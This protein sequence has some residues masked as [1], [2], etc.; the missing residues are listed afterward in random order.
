MK[1]LIHILHSEPP[2]PRIGQAVSPGRGRL[3]PSLRRAGSIDT[4]ALRCRRGGRLPGPSAKDSNPPRR[5]H[6]ITDVG[7]TSQPSSKLPRTG[8]PASSPGNTTSRLAGSVAG[9]LA[10][11]VALGVAQLVAG[12]TGP[13]AAPVVAVGSTAIDITPRPVTELAIS[14]FGPKDKTVLLTGIVVVLAVFAVAFG[15]LAVRRLAFGY[16]GLVVFTAIGLLAVTTRP[17]FRPVDVVPTIAGA[18][19]GVIALRLLVLEARSA[20]RVPPA[21]EETPGQAAAPARRA[22]DAP[23]RPAATG[24]LEAAEERREAPGSPRET[25][26]TEDAPSPPAP[27]PP[28]ATPPA[29]TPP[30]A[31]PPAATPPAAASTPETPPAGTPQPGTTPPRGAP[32]PV[33]VPN[34]GRRRFLVGSALAAGTAAATGLIGNSLSGRR[35][36]AGSRALLRIPAPSRPAP[37][38][39]AGTDLRIPGLSPFVT[40]GGSFYR[41]D[42]AIVLPQVSPQ[43]WQ[44]RVHGMV[45]REVTLTLDDLLH[46]PLTEAWVTLNCVSNPVGGPYIGN[47]KWL[48]VPLASVLR[49]AG[50]KAGADQ[51]LCTSVDGF[52]CGSP[53]QTAMDGRDAL[54]AVA[55]DGS[56]LPVAHGFPVRMI[57]PGLYGYVSA[58]KWVTDIKVTTFSA[59]VAYWV[60]QGWAAQAPVKTASRI[61]V[62]NGGT[63]LT[64]GR[65][66][67]AGVAW[68]QHRGIA[69]VQARADSGPWQ[70]ARLAAVPGIDTWRQWV[71]D[72]DATPGT[73]TLQVRATDETGFTQPQQQEPPVPNGA[74]GWHTVTVNVA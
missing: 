39:P 53:V 33:P 63:R 59:E 65:I 70:Q 45:D 12:I 7:T 42:T 74:Q 32:A 2:S 35:A 30:A 46:R 55:M 47:A 73:H 49:E 16:G 38:L 66:P 36:V 1:I 69:A 15:V 34:L 19:A 67:V 61:D 25:A 10:A 6:R 41:V 72:W 57:V 26:P 5:S 17:A 31:T 44:L 37:P 23:V 20:G 14:V 24:K 4:L 22:G 64:A 51:L 40:P 68:A 43:S 56:P 71:W 60:Q 52:T 29:A 48:G 58:T 54:L 9:L 27:T 18:A 8:A 13:R 21:P 62:P 3:A 11:A 50:I 28:A